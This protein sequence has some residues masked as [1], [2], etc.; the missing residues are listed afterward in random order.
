MLTNVQPKTSMS[1]SLTSIRIRHLILQLVDLVLKPVELTLR[2][3]G[4][5]IGLCWPRLTTN[6]GNRQT[7]TAAMVGTRF[8]LAPSRWAPPFGPS[9]ELAQ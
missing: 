1:R 5:V 3:Y 8:M 4:R 7:A 2:V 6:Q 9:D